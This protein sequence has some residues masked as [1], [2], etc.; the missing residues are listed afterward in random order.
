MGSERPPYVCILM[1][2]YHDFC[3][4]CLRIVWRVPEAGDIHELWRK[5]DNTLISWTKRDLP[6]SKRVVMQ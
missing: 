4:H 5:L 3:G 1:L 2:P 6:G